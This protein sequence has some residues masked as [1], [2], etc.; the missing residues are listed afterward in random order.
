MRDL[1]LERIKSSLQCITIFWEKQKYRLNRFKN[2]ILYP[3]P[4]F[5]EVENLFVFRGFE[6]FPEFSW[7]VCWGS[8]NFREEC[9]RVIDFPE[10]ILFPR[11]LSCFLEMI[12]ETRIRILEYIGSLIES[13]EEILDRIFSIIGCK[14]EKMCNSW[15]N[16]TKDRNEKYSNKVDNTHHD[17]IDYS[18]NEENHYYSSCI[19]W[20]SHVL[21]D[22]SS[23]EGNILEIIEKFIFIPFFFLSKSRIL[24]ESLIEHISDLLEEASC[25]LYIFFLYDLASWDIVIICDDDIRWSS[26]EIR[27]SEKYEKKSYKYEC[28]EH[29]ENSEYR[30]N[31]SKDSSRK[32]NQ[33]SDDCDDSK[34]DTHTLHD[35]KIVTFSGHPELFRRDPLIEI[36]SPLIYLWLDIWRSDGR[37]WHVGKCTCEHG[38]LGGGGGGGLEI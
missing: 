20:S 6:D 14:E 23:S 24:E 37:W 36:E 31:R 17:T 33:S 22:F 1:Y 4:I 12:D 5:R 9:E 38:Y 3:F 25:F 11:I 2:L 28:I 18:S 34:R 15:E 32:P 29:T 10:K 19:S 30:K 13:R 35:P 16:P 7:V 26:I 27:S 8:G 21:D